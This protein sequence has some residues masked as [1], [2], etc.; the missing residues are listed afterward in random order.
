MSMKTTSSDNRSEGFIPICPITP[1]HPDMLIGSLVS[2][3]AKEL[4]TVDKESE[5]ARNTYTWD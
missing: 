5:Y 4:V 3:A 1:E 2:Q